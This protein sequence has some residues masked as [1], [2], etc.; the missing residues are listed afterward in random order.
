MGGYRGGSRQHICVVLDIQSRCLKVSPQ[1]LTPSL[2][3]F[4]VS[5]PAQIQMVSIGP[6]LSGPSG[7]CFLGKGDR[8]SVMGTQY[9][10]FKCQLGNLKLCPV[11]T[12]SEPLNLLHPCNR[13]GDVYFRGHRKSEVRAQLQSLLLHTLKA[14]TAV[15]HS[16]LTSFRGN[17]RCR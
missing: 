9:P 1:H 10:G 8:M 11:R 2:G 15:S 13:P 12:V 17:L 6:H 14:R 4:P 7:L 16:S 5:Q 3:S